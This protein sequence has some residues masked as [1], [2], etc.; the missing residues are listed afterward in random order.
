MTR[1]YAR[2]CFSS[3]VSHYITHIICCSD[4]KFCSEPHSTPCQGSVMSDGHEVLASSSA[5]ICWHSHT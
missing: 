5:G 1:L 2:D 4:L 3:M